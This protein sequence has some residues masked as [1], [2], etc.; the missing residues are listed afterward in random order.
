M[1]NCLLLRLSKPQKNE[2]IS[3]KRSRIKSSE[4]ATKN[5]RGISPDTVRH[6]TSLLF[7]L[8]GKM[9]ELI[10]LLKLAIAV[11]LNNEIQITYILNYL[12]IKLALYIH[13][14]LFPKSDI[15]N[16]ISSQ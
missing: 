11:R 9:K 15:T 13:N 1:S 10:F 16:N 2:D 5:C 4:T 6:L 14:S 7:Y 8:Q 3:G 12:R